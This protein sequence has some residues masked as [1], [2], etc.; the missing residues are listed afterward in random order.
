MQIEVDNVT[1]S[2][3]RKA[4]VTGLSV[5]KTNNKTT[6]QVHVVSMSW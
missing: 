2:L 4:D 3:R 5:G 1:K 6:L